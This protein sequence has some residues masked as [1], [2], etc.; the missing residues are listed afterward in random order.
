MKKIKKFWQV[1]SE[2]VVV[3]LALYGVSILVLCLFIPPGEKIDFLM[4]KTQRH[5]Q[6]TQLQEIR[7]ARLQAEKE[8][9]VKLDRLEK[10][11]REEK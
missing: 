7:I 5:R 3:C 1:F 2:I 6:L 10:E 11:I 9:H 8:R 4:A